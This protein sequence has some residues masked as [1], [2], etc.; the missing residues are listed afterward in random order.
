[1]LVGL[2]RRFRWQRAERFLVHIAKQLLDWLLQIPVCLDLRQMS[3]T[4]GPV[5]VWEILTFP[6]SDVLEWIHRDARK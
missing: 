1:M 2:A 3:Q 4:L 6:L 5:W